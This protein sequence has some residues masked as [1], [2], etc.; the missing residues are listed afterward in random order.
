MADSFEIERIEFIPVPVIYRIE[1][2][3]PKDAINI[4]KNVDNGVLTQKEIESIRKT[5][6][7]MDQKPNAFVET[8]E[9][10]YWKVNGECFE[11]IEKEL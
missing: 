11:D 3:S 10:E 8:D 4:L 9:S 1:A 5:R 6:K 7:Q 2:D